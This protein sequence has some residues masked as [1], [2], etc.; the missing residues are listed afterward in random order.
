MCGRGWLWLS[1]L[2]VLNFTPRGRD[3]W[4]CPYLMYV[5]PSSWSSSAVWKTDSSFSIQ[6]RSSNASRP[7][8]WLG[9]FLL[10]ALCYRSLDL[11]SFYHSKREVILWMIWTIAKHHTKELSTP[12]PLRATFE[13]A[14][15]HTG[16]WF[17]FLF[18]ISLRHV[19]K[20]FKVLAWC[21][22]QVHS[23]WIARMATKVL[24]L[25]PSVLERGF[26]PCEM[27]FNV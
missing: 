12:K 1:P 9:A 15:K 10:G 2:Q 14:L 26:M 24:A 11:K 19:H 5:P 8:R 27:S 18:V 7:L 13:G 22:V 16:T 3:G 17:T 6:L 4:P 25:L 20:C 21:A 23:Q